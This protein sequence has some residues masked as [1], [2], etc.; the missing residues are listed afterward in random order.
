MA[1][2]NLSRRTPPYNLEAEACVLGSMMLDP[3]VTGEIVQMLDDRS[4]YSSANQSIY[5]ALVD[6]FDHNRPIDPVILRE[7]LAQGGRLTDVGGAEYLGELMQAVPSAAHGVHYANIVKEKAVTRK[8]MAVADQI[9]RDCREE[10]EIGDELLDKAEHLIFDIAQ[11]SASTD[12][13]HIKDILKQTMEQIDRW[14]EVEGRLTGLAT[15]FADID[16]MTSGLQAGQLAIVAGRPS[17][18]KSS[19]VLNVAEHVG[20]K[21]KK[22][23][24]V[25][26]IETDNRQLVQNLL[27]MHTHIDAHK[28]RNGKLKKEDYAK[29]SLACGALSEAPIIVDDSSSLTP[30]E[31]RAKARRLKSQHDIQL[32]I[33]DYV[34]LMTVPRAEN[35]QLEISEVS[36]SLK[37]I[38]KE[39]KI[40]VLA[41]AQLSRAAE[42]FGDQRPRM[43]SLRE[44]GALEQDA[45]LVMLLYR[46][47]YYA[48]NDEDLKGKA[49]VIIAK[50]RHGPTG[51][52]HLAFMSSHMRFHDLSLRQEEPY[53]P[54][55]R[56]MSQGEEVPARVSESGAETPF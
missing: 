29:L 13:Y 30:L 33:L 46:P 36:R 43:S 52:V 41:C 28:M 6:L 50:Q 23:V 54:P 47:E 49:E 27:C 53:P 15:G 14:H 7:A 44:S 4:F 56:R 10:A 25:F 32:L 11:K 16:Q 55:G 26:S 20:L 40:P 21:L 8:L 31:L 45:D 51:T 5:N 1:D 24:A 48:P 42:V 22:P 2:S 38:A 39:L 19:F 34:Q 12:I 9:L 37:G 3:A 18:G 35:R 17:M